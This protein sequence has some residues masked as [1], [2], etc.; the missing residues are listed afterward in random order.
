MAQRM[1]AMGFLSLAILAMMLPNSSAQSG[2]TT[3]LISM[4]SCL[5]YISGNSSTPSSSCCS[6]LASVVKNNPKCLCSVLNGGGSS[7]G[8][9]INTTKALEMPGACNVKTP[10]VSDCNSKN[11]ATNFMTFVSACAIYDC[12]VIA[13][14]MLGKDA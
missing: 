8:Y 5:G 4:A 2:C 11:F 9:T 14:L 6:A 1:L 10:P 7:F 3:E 13:K 12:L